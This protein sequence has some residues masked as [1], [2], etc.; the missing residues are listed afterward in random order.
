MMV[1]LQIGLGSEAELAGARPPWASRPASASAARAARTRW[2]SGCWDASRRRLDVPGRDIM[3]RSRQKYFTSIWG[4]YGL[5]KMMMSWNCS[6]G[7]SMGFTRVG[8]WVKMKRDGFFEVED[9]DED[10]MLIFYKPC[11]LSMFVGSYAINYGHV[12]QEQQATDS[13][14]VYN[15]SQWL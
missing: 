15:S 3:G 9:S 11:P 6:V 8:G 7:I 4:C 5:V 13:K 10:P 1:K 14:L 12:F 2:R